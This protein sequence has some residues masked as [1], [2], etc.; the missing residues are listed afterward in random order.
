MGSLAQHTQ[1]D[2]VDSPGYQEAVIFAIT[3]RCGSTV[4]T[5]AIATMGL[6]RYVKEVF[7]PRGASQKLYDEV[8]G[9]S[10]QDYLNSVHEDASQRNTL[11]FKTSWSD[12]E[13][14]LRH[15]TLASLFPNLRIVYLERSDKILQAVSLYKAAASNR[16]HKRKDGSWLESDLRDQVSEEAVNF[17]EEKIRGYL[18]AI[19]GQCEAWEAF[20][21]QNKIAPYRVSYERFNH[22]PQ[23]T[24]KG[25]YKFICN[26]AYVGQVELGYVKLQDEESSDWAARIRS[27]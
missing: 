10:L 19:E 4:I 23:V 16:F 5:E 27:G 24:L 20:F 17:D 9:D 6:A 12:L 7:N 26:E 2:V 3:P 14:V 8:G 25:I 21:A 22:N 13:R 18:N 11:L 1:L 15:R